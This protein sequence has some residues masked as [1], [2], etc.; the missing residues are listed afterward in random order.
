VNRQN[1]KLSERRKKSAAIFEIQG[2]YGDP[3]LFFLR[4]GELFPHLN[5]ITSVGPKIA[6]YSFTDCIIYKEAITSPVGDVVDLLREETGKRETSSFVLSLSC[7]IKSLTPLINNVLLRNRE[8]EAPL[9][10]SSLAV[11]KNL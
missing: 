9:F 4:S 5:F 3:N 6:H 11:A 2:I 1:V 10:S 8:P 7:Q